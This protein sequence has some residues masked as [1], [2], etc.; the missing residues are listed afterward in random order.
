MDWFE[1]TPAI[2]NF[3]PREQSFPE[4]NL[5]GEIHWKNKYAFIGAGFE[6]ERFPLSYSDG[7]NETGLS[8]ASL[9]LS[10]SE[11]PRSEPD[12]PLIYNSS[13]VAY[14]LGNFKNI[15]QVEVELSNITIVNINELFPNAYSLVHYIIS[16][17]Y[18]ENLIIEFIDHKMLVYKTKMGI[19]TNQPTY[20]WQLTNQTFYGQLSLNDNTNI[21]CGEEVTGSGQFG[22]P[23][24]P[25]PQSRFIRAAFLQQTAFKPQNTQEAIGM[26]R[27]ILQNISVPIGTVIIQSPPPIAGSFD[28]T[29]WSII[30]D[31]TNPSYYFYSDF[32]SKL[33]G[34]H[35]GKLDLDA[36]KQKSIDIYQPGWYKDISLE[37]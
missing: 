32:N 13:F 24:D 25:S 8:A 31:H 11:Y 26:A 20:D 7:L 3:V 4:L 33:Y 17:A 1:A 19:L 36:P 18:G 10:C 35:L 30:R 5:P 34:I 6:T 21:L 2:V 37:F 23:G 22:I 9:W 29:Q 28:W 15:H 27:Q 14:V 12:K 16:D